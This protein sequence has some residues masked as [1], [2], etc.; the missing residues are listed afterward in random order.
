MYVDLYGI[1]IQQLLCMMMM[2]I[3]F[4]GEECVVI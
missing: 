3:L 4:E 1:C 2:M